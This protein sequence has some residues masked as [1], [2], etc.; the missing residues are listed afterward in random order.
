MT[1]RRRTRAGTRRLREMTALQ[2]DITGESAETDSVSP[3]I[4][5]A[6]AAAWD[7]MTLTT[8]A[9]VSVLIAGDDVVRDLNTDYRGK[10]SATNVLS[11]PQGVTLVELQDGNRKM[12]LL[13]HLGDIVVSLDTAQ[14]EAQAQGLALED[15]LSHLVIH[16]FLHLLG[17]DHQS[18]DDAADMEALE[19]RLLDR[20][21]IADPYRS[22]LAQTSP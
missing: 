6:L 19:T 15:H 14:R 1:K 20:L 2:I 5:K 16:G 21:G 12:P 22:E 10:D 9:E 4:R 13:P 8:D 3:T 17:Y 11:F 7:A 18:A